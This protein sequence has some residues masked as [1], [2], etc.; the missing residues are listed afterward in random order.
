[1]PT[2]SFKDESRYDLI[3]DCNEFRWL[4]EC[5]QKRIRRFLK[6]SKNEKASIPPSAIEQTQEI[7]ICL[8]KNLDR[9]SSDLEALQKRL[10]RKTVADSELRNASATL[11][12]WRSW[13]RSIYGIAGSLCVSL[14]WQSPSFDFSVWSQAGLQRGKIEATLS[15]YKRDHHFDA[16][17]YEKKFFREYVDAPFKVFGSAYACASGMAAFTTAVQSLVGEGKVTGSVLAGASVYFENKE[18]LAKWFGDRLIETDEFDTEGIRAICEKQQPSLIVLDTI[19]NTA[20]VASSDLEKLIASIGSVIRS[21]TYLILDNTSASICFQPLAR[22]RTMPRK[23]HLIVIESLNKF[24]QFG[25]DRATGGIAWGVGAGISR[26]FSYRMHLGTNIP[27]FSVHSLPLPNRALLEKRLL[28]H[29]RNAFI[30]ASQLEDHVRSGESRFVEQIVYPGLSTYPGYAWMRRR[31]FHGAFLALR[32]KEKFRTGKIYRDFVS[33]VI[34]RAR[35]EKIPLIGGTSFGLSPTRVYLTALH[36]S[37][38][39]PFV[40]ISA[41]T[42]TR[43]EIQCIADCIKKEL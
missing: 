20:S 6:L 38:T 23:V 19:G 30:L 1:M 24:H 18:L 4:I 39:E 29:G 10:A 28:R 5:A 42:E 36:A 25:F 17:D 21:E 41:G 32:F 9:R 43:S 3:D 2:V 33:R 8:L 34:R 7:G 27:D 12:D 16:Q 35:R 40:R 22:M 31:T 26:F 15:D 14:D 11:I 37:A 13:L